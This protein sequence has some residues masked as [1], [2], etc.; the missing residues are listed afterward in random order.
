MEE[1]ALLPNFRRL[2]LLSTFLSA[3]VY[4]IQMFCF[5]K[6]TGFVSVFVIVCF[7]ADG[8]VWFI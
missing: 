7:D 5:L 6:C 8:K 2:L 1:K 4:P 3:F